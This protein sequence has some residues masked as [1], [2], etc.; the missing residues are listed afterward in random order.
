MTL[1]QAGE[2]LAVSYLKKKGYRIIERNYR[3]SF[4][5]M[6]IIAYEKGTIIFIEVKTRASEEFGMP[7]ESVHRRK[8]ERMKKIA[9]LYL[10]KLKK[11]MPARFD[12]VSIIM[13]NG[14]PLITLIKDAFEF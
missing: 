4:G 6:D 2:E 9:L 8:R 13:R 12:V 11:E 3:N 10:K 1:G 14:D 5:E 7:F